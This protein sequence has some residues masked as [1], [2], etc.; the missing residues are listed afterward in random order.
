MSIFKAVID[1]LPYPS[2]LDQ[3]EMTQ[4]AQVLRC[5]GGANAGE[6]GDV[7]ATQLL[8]EQSV[9]HFGAGRIGESREEVGKVAIGVVVGETGARAGN[10]L[11][12][13][14]GDL[15]QLGLPRIASEHGDQPQHHT[16]A[17]WLH[18]TPS[19]FFSQNK[20]LNLG[21]IVLS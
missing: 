17:Q 14:A 16:I 1:E 5:A 12:V 18:C 20:G 21:S 4:D 9:D 3:A 10:I 15:T 11:R 2:G 19:W 8:L 13:K 6:R 7:A